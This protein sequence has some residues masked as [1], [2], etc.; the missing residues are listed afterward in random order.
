MKKLLSVVVS[1][2]LAFSCFHICSFAE[3]GFVL[4]IDPNERYTDIQFKDGGDKFEDE[5]GKTVGKTVYIVVLSVLLAASVTV[6]VITLKKGKDEKKALKEEIEKAENEEIKRIVK[7]YKEK[8][9]QR[10]ELEKQIND[11]NSK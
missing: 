1:F 6:L 8:K 5:K 11:E 7:E 2:V 9:R 3:D 10:D 4:P